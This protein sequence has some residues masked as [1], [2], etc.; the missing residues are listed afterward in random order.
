MLSGCRIA[1]VG[2]AVR[3]DLRCVHGFACRRLGR[4][5]FDVDVDH[6]FE[7]THHIGMLIGS[8]GLCSVHRAQH[9]RRFHAEHACIV[10]GNR[11]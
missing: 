2:N 5:F 1:H 8:S 6:A 4:A 9:L 7:R 11:S 10:V 3:E